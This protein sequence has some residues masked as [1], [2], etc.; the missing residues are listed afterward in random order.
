MSMPSLQKFYKLQMKKVSKYIKKYVT[1]EI[2]P[3]EVESQFAPEQVF[4]RLI[5]MNLVKLVITSAFVR[6]SKR[7]TKNP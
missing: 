1:S 4:K 5:C 2:S 7:D 3:T 6:Q